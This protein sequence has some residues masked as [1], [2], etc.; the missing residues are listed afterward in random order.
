MGK[1]LNYKC[2]SFKHTLTKFTFIIRMHLFKDFYVMER[3]VKKENIC[4]ELNSILS[5]IWL[6][7]GN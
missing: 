6:V 2:L 1:L 3:N 4:Q 5:M 7:V